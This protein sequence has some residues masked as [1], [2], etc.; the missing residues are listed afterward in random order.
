MSPGCTSC[1]NML[2]IKSLA[3]EKIA[4]PSFFKCIT[5]IISSTLQ[6]IS[7]TL[8]TSQKQPCQELLMALDRS[9]ADEFGY[10]P[11]MRSLHE[12]TFHHLDIQP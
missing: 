9:E 2:K 3:Q 5:T 7:K 6:N 10:R 4:G 1:D 8:K 12:Q 11:A